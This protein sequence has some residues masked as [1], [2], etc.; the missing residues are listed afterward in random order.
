MNN[1]VELSG[2]SGV[3]G[4]V[5]LLLLESHEVEIPKY[6]PWLVIKRGKERKVIEEGLLVRVGHGGVDAR[7]GEGASIDTKGQHSRDKVRALQRAD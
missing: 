3:E 4:V 1:I 6:Y 5:V 2:F 7:A